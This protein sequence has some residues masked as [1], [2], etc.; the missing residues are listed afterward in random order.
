[1]LNSTYLSIFFV[2]FLVTI[3][4]FSKFFVVRNYIFEN[5]YP[6][7]QYKYFGLNFFLTY[8]KGI[9]FGLFNNSG[10]WQN[11][12]F[13]LISI[14]AAIVIL[15]LILSHKVVD[16]VEKIALLLIF[17]GSVGN[18]IDRIMYHQVV[19]F[20]NFYIVLNKQMFNW[21][22]FNFADSYICLGVSIIVYRTLKK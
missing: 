19:D 9:A 5:I 22:I 11:S 7:F 1:M 15:Y 14:L 8:N 21:Y 3:D 2:F 17:G 13:L 16:Y 10:A 20:V 18:I 4:Q 6:L 12:L